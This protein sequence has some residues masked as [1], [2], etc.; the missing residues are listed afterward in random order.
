MEKER[1]AI[2]NYIF[3]LQELHNL[4]I[5]KSKHDFTSQIGE[6]LVETIYDGKRAESS[7][8]KGWDI[9]VN[10]Y[11]IQ[12][13][14]HA[15]AEGN[16]NRWSAVDRNET[17]KIDELIIIEFTPYYKILKFYKVPWLEAIKHIKPRNIKSPR[18]ELSWS[19]IESFNINLDNLPKQNVVSIFR[20]E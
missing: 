2:E 8:Q 12:V 15:K 14:A 18:F 17:E 11:H 5:L 10:G 13:K 3:A 20:Q 19:S 4:G 16:N 6:W 9:D 1:F 7:I